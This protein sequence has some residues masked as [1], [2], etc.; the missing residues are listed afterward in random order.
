M[1]PRG[2]AGRPKAKRLTSAASDGSLPS[3]PSLGCPSPSPP[4]GGAL[5][6]KPRR[7]VVSQ[8]RGAP[9][10]ILKPQRPEERARLIPNSLVLRTNLGVKV[11]KKVV[12]PR[13]EEQIASEREPDTKE[14]KDKKKKKDK[15]NKKE[16]KAKKEKED[17][18]EEIG[19]EVAETGQDERE[20]SEPGARDISPL[21]RKAQK[22]KG[23]EAQKKE[24][25]VR[26]TKSEKK[27]KTVKT[28]KE[29]KKTRQT[30]LEDSK[31]AKSKKLKKSE[32]EETLTA[33]AERAPMKEKKR[34][35][36]RDEREEKGEK[37]R[38]SRREERPSRPG[39]PQHETVDLP[40][41]AATSRA[42]HR[43]H[44][45]HA[46]KHEK[47]SAPP[48]APREA[49]DRRRRK[50]RSESR[51]RRRR[52]RAILP[53]D[54]WQV[55]SAGSYHPWSA[56]LAGAPF[57]V[58]SMPGAPLGQATWLGAQPAH[59]A[60][61][62][63]EQGNLQGPDPDSSSEEEVE[64]SEELEGREHDQPEE[65]EEPEME[66]PDEEG[67]QTKMQEPPPEVVQ[68]QTLVPDDGSATTRTSEGE[69]SE[70]ES[71]DEDAEIGEA[72]VARRLLTQLPQELAEGSEDED[73]EPKAIL[74]WQPPGPEKAV[75]PLHRS[76]DRW[77]GLKVGWMALYPLELNTAVQIKSS[78]APVR[79]GPG[80]GVVDPDASETEAMA[81]ANP[82]EAPSL[83]GGAAV[84]L[85]IPRWGSTRMWSC[86]SEVVLEDTI[87]WQHR[88]L[89]SLILRSRRT[90]RTSS[91]GGNG[92]ENPQEPSETPCG[93]GS[94]LLLSIGAVARAVR[95]V[96][97][98]APPPLLV[99][100][101]LRVD[102]NKY[103]GAE[104]G[105]RMKQRRPV[106]K[107][108]AAVKSAAGGPPLKAEVE[109]E[110][111]SKLRALMQQLQD[112]F[113]AE[114][115][116]GTF[117]D[118]LSAVD[119]VQFQSEFPQF[120]HLVGLPATSK[121]GMQLRG[122]LP[123]P[124][125]PKAAFPPGV[126]VP[127][128][129]TMGVTVLPANVPS[130]VPWPKV[131]PVLTP[132]VVKQQEVAWAERLTFHDGILRADMSSLQLGDAGLARW[133][134]WAPSL[135][136][137]LGS[138]GGAPLSNADLNFS[139]NGIEDSGLRHLLSLLRSCD[140]HVQTLNLDANR[141]TEA[142][143]VA[144]SD[145]IAESRFGV[146][147]VHMENNRVQGSYGLM[148]LTRAIKSN[149]KY[150]M[151]VKEMQRYTPFMLYLAGNMIER[152]MQ[153]TQLV[154]EAL[155]NKFPSL[156]EERQFWEHKLQCP[157]LQLPCFDKQETSL[158]Q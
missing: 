139:G 70:T 104:R 153:V 43:G 87:R 53:P 92:A 80:K 64:E 132:E 16:N 110:Y 78:P 6:T 5:T 55:W 84:P 79:E 10:A 31:K 140:I 48:Q 94:T 13:G 150:P 114:Q 25:K 128:A 155:D 26:A 107:K 35:R 36:E 85:M 15:K 81:D 124:P 96:Q 9:R 69:E 14:V 32:E 28:D 71:Q 40:E 45:S 62:V 135:L 151:F 60:H 89:S 76:T 158:F 38:S 136:K 42:G 2:K 105:I 91:G 145:L 130:A 19:R 44:G 22:D 21:K 3:A 142:S 29:R 46:G 18:R 106:A 122:I 123:V 90:G 34:K 113:A 111:K 129:S 127:I 133:C 86:P 119:R 134:A 33:T 144:I 118:G 126:Q 23:E 149:A 102:P 51:S 115:A 74:R 37:K 157:P 54:A 98:H 156:S 12:E 39:R 30:P 17:K 7:V 77:P 147:A 82:S 137:T 8:S 27:D 59:I 68:V 103:R 95:L 63:P 73:S 66:E 75:D 117:W 49:R 146:S 56:Q 88:R 4:R 58:W 116:V 99:P 138:A 125:P 57:G 20:G 131:S 108:K 67:E 1:D 61:V 83:P 52:R 112:G 97:W 148:L 152:P 93:N 72:P 41:Q 120:M 109:D 154:K 24:E 100:E 143:L 47:M 141:L 121:A 65:T 11:Q 101:D 50:E